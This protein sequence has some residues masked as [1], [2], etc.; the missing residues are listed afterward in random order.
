MF[1]NEQQAYIKENEAAILAVLAGG[2]AGFPLNA[3]TGRGGRQPDA[4]SA[5][6]GLAVKVNRALIPH[7]PSLDPFGRPF[8][9]LTD[10]AKLTAREQA[11]Y[12]TKRGNPRVAD[13]LG[14]GIVWYMH[15]KAGPSLS[16]THIPAFAFRA[17]N[18]VMGANAG[19]YAVSDRAM[20]LTA[21]GLKDVP[22]ATVPGR[23]VRARKVKV[24][25]DQG[26][27]G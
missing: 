10:L 20:V 15:D 6:I 1:T 5:S 4:L 3:P 16:G 19:Y 8:P 9:S 11:G 17:W 12:V 22:T 2:N 25:A 27:E 23:K 13:P 14:G 21:H 26:G 24:A 7:W 18:N